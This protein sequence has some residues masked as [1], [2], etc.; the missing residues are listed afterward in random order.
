MQRLCFNPSPPFSVFLRVLHCTAPA[1]NLCP[2]ATCITYHS[3]SC[4]VCVLQCCSA[5]VG[6]L[7]CCCGAVWVT[8]LLPQLP[9]YILPDLSVVLLRSRFV[10]GVVLSLLVASLF[11]KKDIALSSPI[12]ISYCPVVSQYT[13]IYLRAMFITRAQR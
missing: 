5:A 1:C 13:H 4:R 10:C 12:M 8:P 11:L 3:R 6:L 2:L 9:L 7:W